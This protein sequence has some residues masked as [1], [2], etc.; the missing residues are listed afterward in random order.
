MSLSA[1]HASART[2]HFIAHARAPDVCYAACSLHSPRSTFVSLPLRV[3]SISALGNGG[4]PKLRRSAQGGVAALRTRASCLGDGA[5]TCARCSARAPRIEAAQCDELSDSD[6]LLLLQLMRHDAA[7]SGRARPHAARGRATPASRL[8]IRPRTSNLWNTDRRSALLCG[9]CDTFACANPERLDITLILQY[10]Y[11]PM[12]IWAKCNGIINGV[13][14]SV[15]QP[16][17]M[18]TF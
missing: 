17:N 6:A 1:A 14:P 2:C 16:L 18:M 10:M 8:L 3:G 9:G 11:F 7:F 15:C 4:A 5:S 12:A 13:W